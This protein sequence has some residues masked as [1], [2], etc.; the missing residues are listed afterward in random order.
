MIASMSIVTVLVAIFKSTDFAV[1]GFFLSFLVGN[2]SFGIAHFI[3]ES[4]E[5]KYSLDENI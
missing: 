3:Y 2:V 4:K 5:R 1:Y